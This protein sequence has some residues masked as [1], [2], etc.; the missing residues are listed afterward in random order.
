[1]NRQY[2]ERARTQGGP[3][4]NLFVY[5]GAAFPEQMVA[6]ESPLTTK[7]RKHREKED[8]RDG[9]T[10]ERRLLHDIEME[11]VTVFLSFICSEGK[12]M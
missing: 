3:S 6:S 1:M 9:E 2:S 4:T 8:V 10:E 11:F 12:R 7:L 5:H